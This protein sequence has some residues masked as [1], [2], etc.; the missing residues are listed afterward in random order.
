M[1]EIHS[2]NVHIAPRSS[3]I[4]EGQIAYGWYIVVD[5][6][7][8][9]TDPKGVAAVDADGRTYSEKL[10]GEDPRI[11]ASRLLKK[12]RLAL[13]GDRPSGFGRSKLNYPKSG[14]W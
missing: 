9:L 11:I 2:I 7:V 1:P 12:L 6:V 14:I 3:R 8:T 13:K 4:P 5:D 10:N